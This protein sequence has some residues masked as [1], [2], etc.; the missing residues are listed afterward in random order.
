MT[1][2]REGAIDSSLPVRRPAAPNPMT[3]HK[4]FKHVTHPGIP[5]RRPALAPF[6]DALLPKFPNF[7]T[8]GRVG[9]PLCQ[10]A[11]RPAA[12]HGTVTQPL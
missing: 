12:R 8:R 10:L 5:R 2:C 1:G 3:R 6:L 9:L 7:R 11:C 4:N